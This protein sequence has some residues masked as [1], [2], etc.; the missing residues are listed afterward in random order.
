MKEKEF[1]VPAAPVLEGEAS[2]A[3]TPAP[4]SFICEAT[5]LAPVNIYSSAASGRCK[6]AI[7]GNVENAAHIVRCVNSHAA[8][9]SALCEVSDTLDGFVDVVDGTEGDGPQPNWAMRLK[10][11]V[12]E[13]I[14]KAEG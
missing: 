7:V 11:I 4:W 14:A 8:M 6:V 3:H 10:S 9:L 1:G 2:P 12:D 5:P 13:A